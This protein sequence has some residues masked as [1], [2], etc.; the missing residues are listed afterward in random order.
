MASFPDSA[1]RKPPVGVVATAYGNVRLAAVAGPPSP[2]VKT[3]GVPVPATVLI[4][5]LGETHRTRCASQSAIR[6][7]PSGV[8]ASPLAPLSC[9]AVAGPPSPALP[10]T[11]VPTT[12][13]MIPL[14]DTRR[15]RWL[16]VS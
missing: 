11:P 13:V 3:L 14:G 15:T 7:P 9:A 4:T 10:C 1:I 16:P 8:V 2:L 5:P 12:V 6:K